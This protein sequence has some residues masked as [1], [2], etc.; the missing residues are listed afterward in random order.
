MGRLDFICP[1]GIWTFDQTGIREAG[2][3]T[4]ISAL[5]PWVHNVLEE[6][7]FLALEKRVCWSWTGM[8]AQWFGQSTLGGN[9]RRKERRRVVCA[10]SEES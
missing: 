2:R 9:R 6:W 4:S 3:S 5:R 7:V 8:M 10:V 1:I